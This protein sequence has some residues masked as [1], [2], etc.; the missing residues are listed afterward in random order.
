MYWRRFAIS[1]IPVR[2]SAAFALWVKQV[3]QEKE[4]LLEYYGQNGRFP[5]DDGVEIDALTQATAEPQLRH[6]SGFIETEVRIGHWYEVGQIFVVMAALAMV[7]N[8]LARSWNLV[9]Y[10][11]LAGAG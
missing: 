11:T 8:V 3:W 9:K 2:N 6:G 1:S 5:S 7:A 4:D 10:G